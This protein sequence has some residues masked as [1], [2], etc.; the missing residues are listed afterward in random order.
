MDESQELK[1][2]LNGELDRNLEAELRAGL[3]SLPA[4]EGFADRVLGR[5]LADNQAMGQQ[6]QFAVLPQKLQPRS[7]LPFFIPRAGF[8]V[9][10]SGI[11]A[12]LLLAIALGGYFGH[13]REQRIAGE[14]ARRQVLLALRIT[15][16]TLRA[17]RSRVDNEHPDNNMN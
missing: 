8:R 17:V 3:R 2:E 6:D 13:R 12:A 9:F 14:H 7:A 15:G 1:G 5:A 4:P 16:L 11:A 10:R